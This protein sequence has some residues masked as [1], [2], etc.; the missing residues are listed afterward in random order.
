MEGGLPFIPFIYNVFF[1]IFLLAICIAGHR[2]RDHCSR[3]Q[4]AG[5]LYLSPEPEYPGTGLGPLIP[6]PN[7]FRHCH[8][9]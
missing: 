6:V 1:T 8:V 7:W 2:H 4:H 3:H 9:C 5:I